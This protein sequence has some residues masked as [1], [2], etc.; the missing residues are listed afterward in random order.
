MREEMARQKNTRTMVSV[1]VPDYAALSHRIQV[2]TAVMAQRLA[3]Q[4]AR[5]QIAAAKW[6]A[7]SVQMDNSGK[8]HSP[9]GAK[10]AEIQ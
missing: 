4:S 7:V 2:Q 3:A 10:R 8:R 1:E 6:Q 9:C 5:I